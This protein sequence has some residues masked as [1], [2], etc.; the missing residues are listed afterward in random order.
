MYLNEINME[1][2]TE[3]KYRADLLGSRFRRDAENDF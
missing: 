1:Q 2:V 3:Q